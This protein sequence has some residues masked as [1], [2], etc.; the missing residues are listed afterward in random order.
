MA[1]STISEKGWV[2]IPKELRKRYQLKKGDKVQ[3]I[4]Y[5]RV[6]AIVPASRNT[7]KEAKGILKGETSLTEALLK[8]REEDA[9]KDK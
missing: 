1:L 4:D 2:V 5:G 9:K 3:F 7:L 6:I 8:S